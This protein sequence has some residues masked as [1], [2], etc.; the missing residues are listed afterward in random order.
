MQLLKK[1]FSFRG[2]WALFLLA[3]AFQIVAPDMAFAAT[4]SD[5]GV[6]ESLAELLGVLISV[7]TF[8]SLLMMKFFGQ[9]MGTNM[10]T[11]PEAM[12]SLTP[13]WVWVRNLTNILFVIVLVGLAFSNLFA[14]FS[15]ENG[16]NW[17][18]KE[19]LPKVIIALVAINF[20]LLAF[21]VV[22]DAVNVG[23]VAI[24][25]IADS[26]LD[27]DNPEQ[28]DAMISAKTWVMLPEKSY[29]KLKNKKEFDTEDKESVKAGKSCSKE[30]KDQ[31]GNASGVL[32]FTKSV[33]GKTRYYAC[34][35]FRSQVN[36]LF[37]AGW[38]KN[39]YDDPNT[40]EE[41]LDDDCLFVLKKNT[42]KSLLS[43]DDE[44]GQNLFMAFGTNFMHLERLPA[45]AAKINSLNGVL[46]NTLFSAILGIAYVVV[47]VAI[48]IALLSRVIVLWIAM[49]FS[50]L[51]IAA[52]IMGFGEGKA[53]EAVDQLVK[54]LI[55]PLK[56]AAAFAVGFVMMSGMIEFEVVQQ[57]DAFLFGPALSNLGIEEYGFLW[58]MA[59]IVLFWMAAKWA[60]D[61]NLAHDITDKIFTGAQALGEVAA[62]AATI[63]RQ[64]FSVGT[65]GSDNKFSMSNILAAPDLF[66]THQAEVRNKGRENLRKALGF[67]TPEIVKLL[68]DTKFGHDDKLE[69]FKDDILT[70]FDSKAD[71][72]HHKSQVIDMLE[73]STAAWAPGLKKAIEEHGVAEGFDKYATGTEGLKY[74]TSGAYH[75]GE[76][77]NGK[78][79]FKGIDKSSGSGTDDKPENE[80]KIDPNS[81]TIK[82]N[83]S[84]V[85]EYSGIKNKDLDIKDNENLK[86]AAKNADFSKTDMALLTTFAKKENSNLSE[87]ELIKSYSKY[88][89]SMYGVD[90]TGV[91]NRDSMDTTV[92]S[93]KIVFKEKDN[94]NKVQAV[95]LADR[96]N[97]APLDM[98]E[99]GGNSNGKLTKEQAQI[100]INSPQLTDKQKTVIQKIGMTESNFKNMLQTDYGIT[101]DSNTGSG[102][103]GADTDNGSSS[104]QNQN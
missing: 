23:T 78:D 98:S 44:P 86:I 1:L 87:E 10:I 75:K 57:G 30:H 25:G 71:A 4:S 91:K 14:S 39:G 96:R 11:G 85:G 94:D 27:V 29:E 47:L 72:E 37:C 21:R 7:L 92:D 82:D 62:R 81:V 79:F 48:F 56:I 36:D 60:I 65:G 6:L 83:D 97:G 88:A 42:F 67:E 100:I 32:T 53:G 69:K 95:Y 35:N 55:M 70:K 89:K 61:G 84:T 13:M 2:L 3:L 38:E 9:L 80:T 8:L 45:L 46:L 50:P 68:H 90:L 20:S 15:G 101:P 17:T 52:S 26:R 93:N 63:D 73:R 31:I 22:I 76:I 64:I 59:T 41:K 99:F 28:Q 40:K 33:D 102:S 12:Q 103:T 43:P 24:L 66:R 5:K 18:I 51:L 58:Q 54:N 16:G 49:V 19:K 104:S 74:L 34:R 77:N